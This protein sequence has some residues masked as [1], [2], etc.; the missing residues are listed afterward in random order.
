[1]GSPDDTRTG[2]SRNP[3]HLS[4]A[5]LIEQM[6]SDPT[7]AA[8]QA[9][10]EEKKKTA[11]EVGEERTKGVE[12]ADGNSESMSPLEKLASMEL[13]GDCN[14]GEW[15]HNVV[16]APPTPPTRCYKSDNE[17]MEVKPRQCPCRP[18]TL[19]V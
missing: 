16:D 14:S 6:H 2:W 17:V 8:F 1:M 10:K 15:D 18:R 7:W 3:V 19:G 4:R 12:A 9:M 5:S 13:Y 11:E